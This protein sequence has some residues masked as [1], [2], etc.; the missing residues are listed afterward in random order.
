MYTVREISIHALREERDKVAGAGKAY[1][2]RFQSTRSARSATILC[3]LW[4]DIQFLFQSTRSA[5][6]ATTHPSQLDGWRQISIHALREERDNKFQQRRKE[7]RRI[8][9]HALRE[10][11][12]PH[13]DTSHIRLSD[14]NPRAPRGARL[15]HPSQLDGWRQISIHALREERDPSASKASKP[16]MNFNPRAPRGARPSIDFPESFRI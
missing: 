1:Y 6:S 5:R 7:Y 12:D 16:A 9:I 3:G 2:V 14:F 11:R 10:E 13:G 15:T 8:S 4:R